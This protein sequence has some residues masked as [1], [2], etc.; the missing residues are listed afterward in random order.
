MFSK[1]TLPGRIEYR[2]ID[3]DQP[4]ESETDAHINRRFEFFRTDHGDTV[5]GPAFEPVVKRTANPGI[6]NGG[7][8]LL[9][10]L[11]RRDAR[12]LHAHA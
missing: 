1:F 4:F 7:A 5:H 9:H 11:F 8:P 6:D 3:T 2:F 10:Q 12:S